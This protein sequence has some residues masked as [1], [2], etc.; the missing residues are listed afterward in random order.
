MAARV[1]LLCT[2]LQLLLPALV[3]VFHL[4]L[5]VSEHIAGLLSLSVLR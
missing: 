1:F 5:P 2:E 4:K 3:T